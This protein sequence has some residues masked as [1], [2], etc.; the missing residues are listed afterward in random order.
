M[1][2]ALKFGSTLTKD[3]INHS[4]CCQTALNYYRTVELWTEASKAN[5]NEGRNQL[6]CK[7]FEFKT[8][9]G[10]KSLSCLMKH[11]K[12]CG[13]NVVLLPFSKHYFNVNC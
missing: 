3:L 4:L 11:R 13:L 9:I 6:A 12:H 8:F 7:V 1:S 10:V 2:V 5:T